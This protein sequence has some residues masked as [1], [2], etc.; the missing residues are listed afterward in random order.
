[1]TIFNINVDQIF[2]FNKPVLS[3]QLYKLTNNILNITQN[4]DS[5]L[6]CQ[7]VS[8]TVV[9]LFL[10]NLALPSITNYKNGVKS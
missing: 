5:K 1:M 10:T 9:T 6:M 3:L 4:D 7:Y 2:N 8:V